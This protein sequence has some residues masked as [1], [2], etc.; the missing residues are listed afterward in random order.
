MKSY[1]NTLCCRCCKA[2]LSWRISTLMIE[3][4]IIEWNLDNHRQ[5][6]TITLDNMII[7]HYCSVIL[8]LPTLSTHCKPCVLL[9]TLAIWLCVI[10]YSSFLYWPNYRKNHDQIIFDRNKTG[11]SMIMTVLIQYSDRDVEPRLVWRVAGRQ[12]SRPIGHMYLISWRN[13]HFFLRIW[14]RLADFQ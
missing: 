1:P 6:L 4:N 3:L 14:K 8:Y 12:V 11:T 10:W 7:D 5:L 9:P 13:T 2:Q